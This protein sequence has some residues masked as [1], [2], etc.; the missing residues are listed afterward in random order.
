MTDFGVLADKLCLMSNYQS[1]YNG[2]VSDLQSENFKT[3]R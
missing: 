1:T 3:D 2:T